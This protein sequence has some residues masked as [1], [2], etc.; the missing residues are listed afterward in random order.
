M[1]PKW[2]D[3]ILFPKTWILTASPPLRAI[4]SG[5]VSG[6]PE[7]GAFRNKP[8]SVGPSGIVTGRESGE[9]PAGAH[10]VLLAFPECDSCRLFFL[11]PGT[12]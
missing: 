9:D 11:R 5:G 10:K 1:L 8:K 4:Q 6:W 7:S 12:G 2:M 3:F